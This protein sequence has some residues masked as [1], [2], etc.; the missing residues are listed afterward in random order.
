MPEQIEGTPCSFWFEI[1]DDVTGEVL[2][3]R[4]GLDSTYPTPPRFK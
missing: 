4:G 3:R 2:E 1:R